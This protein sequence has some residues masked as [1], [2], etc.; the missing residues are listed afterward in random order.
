[1]GASK[2]G[3][4]RECYC[5]KSKRSGC[6][7]G[8]LW[9]SAGATQHQIRADRMFDLAERRR[10]PMLKLDYERDCRATTINRGRATQ[11]SAT[12]LSAIALKT[13]ERGT[14]ALRTEINAL[15]I[16]GQR[17]LL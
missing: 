15:E 14:G 17:P 11:A 13:A 12:K 1:M 10:Q 4:E 2:R 16:I 9:R 7:A 6:G 8:F 5:E 3:C